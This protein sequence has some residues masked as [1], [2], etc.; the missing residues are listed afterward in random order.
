MVG[1][2]KVGDKVRCVFN[3]NYLNKFGCCGRV[4]KNDYRITVAWDD[5]SSDR[6]DNWGDASSFQLIESA[7]QDVAVDVLNGGV[8]IQL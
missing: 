7:A 5:G 6:T 4:I 3:H 1:N 8:I 2:F